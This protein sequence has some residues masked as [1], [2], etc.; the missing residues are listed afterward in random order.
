MM[1]GTEKTVEL[2]R[3]YPTLIEFT[4]EQFRNA[5]FK[6]RSGKVLAIAYYTGRIS[7][8]T[9]NRSMTVTKKI[10]GSGNVGEEM[11]VNIVTAPYS[12]VY[13]VVPSRGKTEM[14]GFGRVIVLY[15]DKEGKASYTFTPNVTGEFVAE[16]ATVYGKDG[17]WGTSE[18]SF[19]TIKDGNAI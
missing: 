16:S 18:R 2:E 15:T 8:N 6:V 3:Y 12:V 13:D 5:N 9:S 17:N 10:S 7:E 19:I 14:I 1:N 4:E 11:T